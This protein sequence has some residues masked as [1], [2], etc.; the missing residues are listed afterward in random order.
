MSTPA[1]SPAEILA[2]LE[3][4]ARIFGPPAPRPTPTDDQRRLDDHLDQIA[5]D[6]AAER[7]GD[8]LSP[9]DRRWG[10][11]REAARMFGGAA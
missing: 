1:Q 3:E 2:A 4:F 10:A 8:W 6:R 11:D 9:S 7:R 5:E